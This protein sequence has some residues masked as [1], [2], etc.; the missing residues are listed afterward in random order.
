MPCFFVLDLLVKKETVTG[1]IGNTQGVISA[2]KPPKNPRRNT[3][4]PLE[5]E[6]VTA[7]LP[8][9][10]SGGVVAVVGNNILKPATLVPLDNATVNGSS[11]A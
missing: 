2:I 1:I 3:S 11:N 5:F 6:V 10:S 8:Q 7:A 9:A 4:Q